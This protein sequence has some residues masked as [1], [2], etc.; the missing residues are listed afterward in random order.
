MAEKHRPRGKH[1]TRQDDY[2]EQD[3]PFLDLPREIR[4]LIYH[5]A[6]TNLTPFDLW[7]EKFI[8][9][10]E[11]LEILKLKKRLE[12]N[13]LSSYSLRVRHQKDLEYFRKEKAVGILAT[14]MQ[15]YDEAWPHLYQHNTFRFSADVHWIGVRRFLT[16]IGERNRAQLRNLE[17]CA[18]V[19]DTLYPLNSSTTEA[20][21]CLKNHP[22]MQMA[23][24]GKSCQLNEN[25]QYVMELLKREKPPLLRELR[26]IIPTG[27]FMG[28]SRSYFPQDS[29]EDYFTEIATDLCWIKLKA[30]VQEG[31]AIIRPDIIRGLHR[32][33]IDIIF[34]E[35]SLIHDS[36]DGIKERQEWMAKPDE[37]EYLTGLSELFIAKEESVPARGGRATRT[38]GVD[39]TAR[40]LKGF[41]GC[42]FQVIN[43]WVCWN[44]LTKH[45]VSKPALRHDSPR[46]YYPWKFC[47]NFPQPPA[48]RFSQYC[49]FRLVQC[50]MINNPRRAAQLGIVNDENH[51]KQW[52]N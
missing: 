28:H 30:V 31:G 39:K 51:I 10:A 22:T 15:V 52:M 19:H 20:L 16:T 9:P 37:L 29:G 50:V 38:A 12:K 35:G 3:S 14:C 41:G 47:P 46:S 5:F 49:D 36:K 7:P 13:G 33:G 4:D 1:R 18:N 17:V 48:W 27:W 8:L 24:V 45:V 44:C 40:V 11:Q 32:D 2:I 43:N 26:F 34:E 23:K 25:V 21:I 42:R 6:L